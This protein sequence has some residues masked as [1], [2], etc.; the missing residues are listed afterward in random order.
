MRGFAAIIQ[1]RMGSSR[2]PEKVLLPIMGKPVLIKLIE[3]LKYSKYIGNNIVVA[4]PRVLESIKIKNVVADADVLCLRPNVSE[5]DVLGRVTKVANLINCDY[6]V[7]ITADCPLID[8][9]N[10]DFLCSRFLDKH[11]D[12]FSNTVERSFPDGFDCQ[13][14]SKDILN[15]IN[16]AVEDPISRSHCGWNIT[17]YPDLFK[18]GSYVAKGKYYH[19]DW[20]LTLDTKPD[21]EVISHIFEH[22]KINNCVETEKIIDYL[23]EHPEILEI[24]RE[25]RTKD[26]KK[27][28]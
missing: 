4:S 11:Y 5:D 9:K 23:L 25:I 8:P 6:V 19:P 14:Y 12:Y 28:M 10:I 2:L 24:N 18:I 1:A 7:E 16:Y 27:E 17:Q 13:V 21:Y 15:K 20:R 26:P 3:R 22:F